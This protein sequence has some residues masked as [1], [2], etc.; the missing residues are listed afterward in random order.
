MEQEFHDDGVVDVEVAVV[1]VGVIDSFE[2]YHDTDDFD[3]KLDGC[4][5]VPPLFVEHG[6]GGDV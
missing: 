4:T 2:W 3:A 6:D 5:H 1:V